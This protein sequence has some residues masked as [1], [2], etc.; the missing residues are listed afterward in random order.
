MQVTGLFH[1]PVKS[2]RGVPVQSLT[3][4][5]EGPLNDRRWMIVDE[6]DNFLSQRALPQLSRLTPRLDAKSL[7]LIAPDGD[8]VEV[9]PEDEVSGRQ[10]QVWK[11]SVAAVDCGDAAAAF[12]S[13]EAGRRCRLVRFADGARRP[14]DPKYAPAHGA[15]T[16]F[17]DGYP[18]LVV[19]EASL[20]ALNLHLIRPVSM[21]RFRPNVVVD[22]EAPWAEDRWRSLSVGAVTLDLVKPC[23][24]CVVT[25]V[26]VDT[27]L[28]SEDGE[29]LRTLKAAHALPGFG[30]VFGQNAVHRGPGT[31]S[32]GDAVASA[33]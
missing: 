9:R 7:T 26:D 30:A 32:L 25:T 21:A 13:R 33:M 14:V 11:D 20:A 4:E 16:R 3:L 19:T 1:Y 18:L 6:S 27:G 2:L 23:A 12:L 22:G 5:A 24:R 10:V 31:I 15:L 28:L 8:A 17:T 29:P